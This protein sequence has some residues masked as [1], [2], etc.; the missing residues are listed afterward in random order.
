MFSSFRIICQK[1]SVCCF[2]QSQ[3]SLCIGI[4]LV[5]TIKL[6]RIVFKVG[7]SETVAHKIQIKN[8]PKFLFCTKESFLFW[9]DT[10]IQVGQWELSFRCQNINK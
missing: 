8:Q 5:K 4:V 2:S 3:L 10:V 6:Q 7:V 1:L 9:W